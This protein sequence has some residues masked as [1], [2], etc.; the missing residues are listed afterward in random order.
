MGNSES[1]AVIYDTLLVKEWPETL[2]NE[3]ER[4]SIIGIE[5][6][7][8]LLI[9]SS[10]LIIAAAVPRP[11][12]CVKNQLKGALLQNQPKSKAIFKSN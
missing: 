9:A 7:K 6:K 11:Y 10:F 3:A 5:L 1:A 2:V 12:M 4:L 8:I